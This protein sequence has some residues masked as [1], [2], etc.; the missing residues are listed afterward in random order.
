MVV[1]IAGSIVV[2]LTGNKVGDAMISL[3][4]GDE[5]VVS[6]ICSKYFSKFVNI[7]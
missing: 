2:Y 4:I 3:V 1:R 6:S 5:E 7:R